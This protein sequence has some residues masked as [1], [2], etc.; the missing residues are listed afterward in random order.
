MQRKGGKVIRFKK[1]FVN[2]LD[3]ILTAIF[4]IVTPKKNKNI[5]IF[6]AFGKRKYWI[7]I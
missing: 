7:C 5:Q 4:S 3:V 2:P 6:N 1:K